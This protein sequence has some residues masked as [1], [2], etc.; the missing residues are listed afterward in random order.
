[1]SRLVRD[2]LIDTASALIAGGA[3]VTGQLQINEWT[4]TV[5]DDAGAFLVYIYP[6]TDHETLRMIYRLEFSE[7]VAC[8]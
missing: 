4:G 1:L 7:A 8:T 5:Y 2:A 3:K 6:L